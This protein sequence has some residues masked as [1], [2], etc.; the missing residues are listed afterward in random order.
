MTEKSII[1][2]GGL[3]FGESIDLQILPFA[4]KISPELA[5]KDIQ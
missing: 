5:I 4:I 1:G 3:F 2:L